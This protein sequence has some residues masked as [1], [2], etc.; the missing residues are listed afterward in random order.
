M[1]NKNKKQP[2]KETKG[3][4]SH[5]FLTSWKIMYKML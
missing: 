1:K 3:F 5:F 4:F 2:K